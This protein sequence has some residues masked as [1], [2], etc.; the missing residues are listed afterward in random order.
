MFYLV[1][2]FVFILWTSPN[3]ILGAVVGMVALAT[4]GKVQIRRGCIEFYGGLLSWLLR[5]LPNGPIAAMTLG[6][7]IVGHSP[8]TLAQ[9]RDHEH[10]H[11]KQYERWGPLFLP[12][13]LGCSVYLRLR[14]RNPYL[15]NPFEIEAYDRFP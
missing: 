5:H 10:I 12:A 9:A 11:V 3:T 8:Q 7:V 15:D 4:G 13:Y 1:T 6:H 14:G 2:R